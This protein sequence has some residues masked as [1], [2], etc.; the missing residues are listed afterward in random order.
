MI[1]TQPP[2]AVHIAQ[3]LF[4]LAR[5]RKLHVIE[6]CTIEG[7]LVACFTVA[8]GAHKH[9]NYHLCARF[10][11]GGDKR[12]GRRE[13]YATAFCHTLDEPAL[14]VEEEA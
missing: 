5:K 9:P 3:A 1:V 2:N 10:D 4:R 8:Y 7:S 11:R 12:H 14:K 13:R 6:A